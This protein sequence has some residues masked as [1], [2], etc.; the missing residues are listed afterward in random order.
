MDLVETAVGVI[1]A[2][3]GS[4]PIGRWFFRGNSRVLS[5]VLF[6]RQCWTARYLGGWVKLRSVAIHLGHGKWLDGSSGRILVGWESCSGRGKEH[7]EVESSDHLKEA[8]RGV[9]PKSTRHRNS[10][11]DPK[12]KYVGREPLGSKRFRRVTYRGEEA[13]PPGDR[14][15]DRI[16]IRFLH[17]F[18]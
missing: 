1:I 16:S 18:G 15:L 8:D 3:A 14:K 9:L 2:D 11:S 10:F 12:R 17:L 5:V 6:G 7:A 13:C 4:E